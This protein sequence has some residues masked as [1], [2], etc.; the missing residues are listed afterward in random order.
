MGQMK[1]V[2]YALLTAVEEI[3]SIYPAYQIL[4]LDQKGVMAIKVMTLASKEGVAF[5]EKIMEVV[6]KE[7]Y[8]KPYNHNTEHRSCGLCFVPCQRYEQHEY[9]H[10]S[11]A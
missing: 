10:G 6:R 8:E 9:E 5:G 4:G 1:K 2:H 11:G 3:L 7:L